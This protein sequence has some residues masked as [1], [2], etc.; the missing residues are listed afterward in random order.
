MIPLFKKNN[1]KRNMK[2]LV[3]V[4]LSFLIQIQAVFYKFI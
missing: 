4:F 3:L 2:V 1:N